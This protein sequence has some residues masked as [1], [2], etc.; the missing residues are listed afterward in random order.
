MVKRRDVLKRRDA[1]AGGHDAF[2]ENTGNSLLQAGVGCSEPS[3]GALGHGAVQASRTAAVGRGVGSPP[4]GH[5]DRG[6]LRPSQLT[7]G[8][9]SPGT[10][11][12]QPWERASVGEAGM[13]GRVEVG[14]PAASRSLGAGAAASSFLVPQGPEAELCGGSRG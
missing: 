8:P 11:T 2:Q 1:A 6:V 5:G 4:P 10:K 13:T 14:E 9:P 3:A 7:T 12:L